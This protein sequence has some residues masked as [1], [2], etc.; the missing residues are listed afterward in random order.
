MNF[1]NYKITMLS[2]LIMPIKQFKAP[3]ETNQKTNF[4]GRLKNCFQIFKSL[5]Y[6]L[7]TYLKN[8]VCYA[9]VSSKNHIASMALNSPWVNLQF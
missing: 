9:R 4:Q 2:P 6:T 7:V 3:I 8:G 1:L 5:N